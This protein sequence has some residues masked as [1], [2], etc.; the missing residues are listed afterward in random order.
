MSQFPHTSVLTFA[1]SRRVDRANGCTLNLPDLL[2]SN[3][4][5]TFVRMVLVNVVFEMW[6]N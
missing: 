3:I 6:E 2:I 1:V 4:P 5:L